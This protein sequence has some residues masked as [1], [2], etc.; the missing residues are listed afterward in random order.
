[1]VQKESVIHSMVEF[2]DGSFIALWP[3][4]IAHPN[5][6]SL[7]I[8][9]NVMPAA[10]LDFTQLGAIHFAAPAHE[11]FPALGLAIAAGRRAGT[12]PAVM[13][14]ANEI[15]VGAFIKKQITFN[16]IAVMVEKVMLDHVIVDRPE[17]EDI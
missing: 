12:L 1:M 16:Q 10:H 7:T 6:L 17:L 4:R 3:L 13:N 15:A 11:R 14:A 8:L 2:C 5:T 9:K